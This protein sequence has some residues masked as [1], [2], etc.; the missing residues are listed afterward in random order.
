M[1]KN[2]EQEEA[3]ESKEAKNIRSFRHISRAT[4][5]ITGIICTVEWMSKEGR[6]FDP[7]RIPYE[8]CR[9]KIPFLLCDYYE[10]HMEITEVMK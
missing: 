1:C 10:R 3:F 5:E 9:K 2:L 7:S 4:S 8:I 6:V